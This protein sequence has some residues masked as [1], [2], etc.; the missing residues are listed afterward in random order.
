ME[1]Y[2]WATYLQTTAAAVHVTK[3]HLA[4]VA[5]TLVSGSSYFFYS[6]ATDLAEADATMVADVTLV[7]GSSF[8]YSAVAVTDSA[9][10]A[11]D[12][13]ATMDADATTVAASS[14]KKSSL[15]GLFYIFFN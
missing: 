9:E 4:D 13:D 6:V 3:D 10:V 12:V 7:S 11:A 14:E 1:A 8:F 2:I 15:C 5:T